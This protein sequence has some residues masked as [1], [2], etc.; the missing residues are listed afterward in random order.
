MESRVKR[1]YRGSEFAVNITSSVPPDIFREIEE[2][3]KVL[4]TTK[5]EVVRRLVVVGLNQYR[6]T[7]TLVAEPAND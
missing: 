5:S 1:R 6:R 4:G 2:L 3:A 7:G